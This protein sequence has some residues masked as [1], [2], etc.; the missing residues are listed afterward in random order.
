[1]DWRNQL[2]T[3]FLKLETWLESKNK[4]YPIV[5]FIAI[6]SIGAHQ[7]KRVYRYSNGSSEVAG[8]YSEADAVRSINAYHDLG[9]FTYYGLPVITYGKKGNP[10]AK[11]IGTNPENW[12]AYTH[13]PPG[14]NWIN[15]WISIPFGNENWVAFRWVALIV[16]LCMFS[17]CTFLLF[18][19]F[20]P[21]KATAI[22]LIF[23]SASMTYNMMHGIFYKGY[24]QSLLFLEITL[25]LK[26]LL[27]RKLNPRRLA[28]LALI[29]F[30]Q[31]WLS[32]D[33]AFVVSFAAIPMSIMTMGLT[34]ASLR[35]FILPMVLVSGAGFTAAHTLHLG[36]VVAYYGG[37]K[38]AYNDLKDAAIQRSTNKVNTVE[39]N[40]ERLG[41]VYQ[42]KQYLVK[43]S[44]RGLH[45]GISFI[46]LTL[47]V[48]AIW[49][50]IDRYNFGNMYLGVFSALSISLLW[51]WVM[52]QH[53]AI[54]TE[55]IP[56]HLFLAYSTMI[57][58]LFLNRSQ[59]AKT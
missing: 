59:I 10:T 58:S 45:F 8:K 31:G 55:A 35:R 33:Y 18:G 3:K 43:H 46:P 16:N 26:F 38:N 34:K 32:F 54:H 47:I 27:D 4:I 49:F 29:G 53:S 37:V 42:T 6:A 51:V 28:A 56:R 12:R 5:I 36:Q 20:R 17:Y 57:F 9:F 39:M 50:L 14:P 41:K 2:R 1:M 44:K 52:T 48:F 40:P 25:V 21:W 7:V 24:S 22:T 19:L 13:Y 23:I 11:D 15:Y 30:I